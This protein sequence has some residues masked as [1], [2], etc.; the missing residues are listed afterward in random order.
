MPEIAAFRAVRY[1]PGRLGTDQSHLIA[2]PYDVLSAADKAELL[3]RSD[4]NIVAIDLPHVPPESAG[5]D[6]VYEE[7]AG[8]LQQWLQD[9]TFITESQPS[10]YVYHQSYEYAGR[11]YTRKKFFARMR[12][13]PFGTGTVF[14]HERTFG[15][16]KE[17]RLKL[18]QAT[19][20]QL[21]AVFGLYSDPANKISGLLDPGDRFLDTARHG[22]SRSDQPLARLHR[23]ASDDH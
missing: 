14:P 7:A 9:G 11:Q 1:N 15:G 19:R 17:D 12:L 22:L 13:E 5:P 18:M 3:S 10:I 8:R 6:A 23:P 20:C 21:S 16:P 4:R 2:P